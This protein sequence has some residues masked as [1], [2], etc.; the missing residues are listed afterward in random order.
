MVS[1]RNI[2][3][4]N[5]DQSRAAYTVGRVG[6]GACIIPPPGSTV[7]T[8]G[9]GLVNATTALD[10][11]PGYVAEYA[12]LWIGEVQGG[13]LMRNSAARRGWW[14]FPGLIQGISGCIAQ[15]PA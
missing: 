15:Q 4:N 10:M 11:D 3:I 5:G 13:R 2:F 1:L 14:G 8:T 9:S 12:S 7:V 6:A